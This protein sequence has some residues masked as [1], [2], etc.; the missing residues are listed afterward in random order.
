MSRTRMTVLAVVAVSLAGA[1]VWMPAAVQNSQA[2]T[3]TLKVPSE[4]K[5]NS[6]LKEF[7]QQ[8]LVASNQVLEGLLTEDY[9]LIEKG[10]RKFREMGN[11]EK[12]RVSNDMMYRTHSEDFQRN[13]DKLIESASK[14]ESLDRIAL[15]W[16]DTTLSCI[17]C[18]RWVRTVLIADSSAP[19]SLPVSAATGRNE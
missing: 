3:Q 14:S 6:P 13:V 12:W 18:H 2:Q 15:A 9:K 16:F 1:V 8:K 19:P 7:M 5:K 17:D 4:T 11:A 10:G